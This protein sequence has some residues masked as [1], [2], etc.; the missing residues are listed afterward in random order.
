MTETQTGFQLR[1]PEQLIAY[2]ELRASL[3]T[4]HRVGDRERA[5]LAVRTQGIVLD[6]GEE[7]LWAHGL[8]R[9]DRWLLCGPDKASLRCGVRLGF[10]DRIVSL[11]ELLDGVVHLPRTAL[12]R[13]YTKRWLEEVLVEIFL[14]ETSAAQAGPQFRRD[15]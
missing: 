4:E 8:G 15:K 7:S 12:K 5:E 1:R 9:D 6:R 2:D 14:A 3:A 11:E 13:H 10:R